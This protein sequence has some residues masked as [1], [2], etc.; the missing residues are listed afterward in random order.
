MLKKSK[1][2][3][4]PRPKIAPDP[5]ALKDMEDFLVSIFKKQFNARVYINRKEW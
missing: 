5:K 3:Q 2:V 1:I 4:N